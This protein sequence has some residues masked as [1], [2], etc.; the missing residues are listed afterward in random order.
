MSR[1]DPPVVGVLFDCYGTLVDILTDERDIE[2]YR[3]LSQW[4]IYQGVR[5]APEDL[6]NLYTCRVSEALE[7]AG[8]PHPEVRVEEIFAGICA[9][10]AA[11]EVDTDR[12]GVES[13]R[14]F[15]AASLRRLGV[16]ERSKRLLDLFS[17]KKTGVVSNGQRVFSEQEMRMLEFYDRLG[18]VIFSSDLGYQKPDPRIYAAALG[19]M[20]LSAPEVLFIGDNPGN[21]VDAPRRLGMQALHVEEA[22]VRYG[23]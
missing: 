7:L 15:R 17:A 5:I 8:E 18:F 1:R 23:V 9:E 6:R 16:I 10:H 19:R 14:A 21:D 2:T 4:L 13:A 22:W 20:R 3:C 12:L 11:W